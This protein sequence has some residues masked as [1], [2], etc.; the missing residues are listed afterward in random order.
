MVLLLNLDIKGDARGSLISLEAQKNIPFEIK[1]VY[2]IFGTQ[3]GVSRGFHAHKAL[4]Q[5][6][7]CVSGSCRFILDDG[8]TSEDIV[9]D[10]PEKSI[11]I[12]PMVWHEMHD[13]SID[14]VI[15]VLASDYYNESDYIRSYESF[16]EIIT[17]DVHTPLI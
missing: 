7:I 11:Y 10:S 6:A 8:H 14:C 13:L 15:L 4:H 12:G 2:Y 3:L 5:V 16:K 17:R 9:L 1:R